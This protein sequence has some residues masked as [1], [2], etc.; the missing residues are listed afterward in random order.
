MNWRSITKEQPQD[1]QEC[2]TDMKHGII[3]GFYNEQDKDFHGYYFTDLSWY[4]QRWV[5][6]EEVKD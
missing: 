6:I 4:A 2:L 3:S 5:P 1:G